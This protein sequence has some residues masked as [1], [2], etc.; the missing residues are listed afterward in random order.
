M[1]VTWKFVLLLLL[2]CGLLAAES[3]PESLPEAVSDNAVAVL[4]LHGQ[5]ELFS[6]MGMGAK[7]TWDAVSN[8]VYAI[9]AA[10]GKAE[11]IHS[12]PGTAGRVG[13]MAVGAADYLF[14]FGG[15]VLYQGGGMAVPD[16]NIYE[17]IGDRWL[18]GT[19]MPIPVG[20]AVI[21]VYR[22]R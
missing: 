16:I 6:V 10:S 5:T 14:L 2:T 20:D 15:Y 7:K 18:R 13:A 12:V 22:D 19:D 1:K 11:A 4:K 21:G 17:P 9:D 3:G 8:Q